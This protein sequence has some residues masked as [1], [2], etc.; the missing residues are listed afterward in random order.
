VP[1]A[2]LGPRVA[3]GTLLLD[4]ARVGARPRG[5]RQPRRRTGRKA[6]A[7]TIRRMDTVMGPYYPRAKYMSKEEFER[8]G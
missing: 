6:P 1:A 5:R 8:L 2:P 7:D 3:R 4:A